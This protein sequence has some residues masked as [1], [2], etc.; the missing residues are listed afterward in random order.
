MLPIE[1]CPLIEIC[2]DD[3]QFFR[4]AQFL[5][6]ITKKERLIETDRDR[7]KQ[8]DGQT[9]SFIK[10]KANLPIESCLLEGIDPDILFSRQ[11]RF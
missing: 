3:T 7:D 1:S 2:L 5:G 10:E 4:Q 6:S 9:D 8:T 11:V